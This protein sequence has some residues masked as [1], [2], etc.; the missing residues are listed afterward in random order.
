[1]LIVWANRSS[2]NPFF[3]PTR[4]FLH[5]LPKAELHVHLNGCIPFP[6]L[7]RLARDQHAAASAAGADGLADD[8]KR[9]INQLEGGVTLERFQ[10]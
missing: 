9:G 6:I 5:S 4:A 2:S 3:L 7:Q 8:I 1:M 10:E